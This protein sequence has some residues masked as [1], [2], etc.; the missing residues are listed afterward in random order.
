MMALNE[1]VSWTG[2]LMAVV[3]MSIF[4]G[5]FAMLIMPLSVSQFQAYEANMSRECN[6]CLNGQ[7]QP[8]L[9]PLSYFGENTGNKTL[10][11]ACNKNCTLVLE[12]A[13]S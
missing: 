8:N 10:Y 2:I 1:N 6:I 13:I 12:N 3:V 4:I 5:T 11:S 9:T 7:G